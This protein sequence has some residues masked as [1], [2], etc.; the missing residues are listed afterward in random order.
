MVEQTGRPTFSHN[1]TC[2]QQAKSER[3]QAVRVTGSVTWMTKLGD[4]CDLCVDKQ[5]TYQETRYSVVHAHDRAR[6]LGL[7]EEVVDAVAEDQCCNSCSQAEA[8]VGR[9]RH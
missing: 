6:N 7:G 8:R 9:W 3:G 2:L 5:S 1:C 4:T